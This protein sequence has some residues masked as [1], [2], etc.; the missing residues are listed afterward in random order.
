VEDPTLNALI[1][2]GKAMPWFT[3]G[4]KNDVDTIQV[5]YL[6]GN[7]IPTIVRSTTPGVLG[8]IWD[9]YL[10]VGVSVMDYRGI[11]KNNGIIIPD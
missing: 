7:E 11:I 9:T 8:F 1:G 3:V 4:D 10:D 6:N 5:D 2:E